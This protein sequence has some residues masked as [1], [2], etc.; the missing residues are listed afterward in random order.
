[1][2]AAARRFGLSLDQSPQVLSHFTP[3][4]GL[5][6]QRIRHFY[7]VM[8]AQALP[9]SPFLKTSA[10]LKILAQIPVRHA[11]LVASAFTRTQEHR[12]TVNFLHFVTALTLYSSTHWFYKVKCTPYTVIFAVFDFDESGSITI[13]EMT[14]MGSAVF[15]AACVMT[16][17]QLPRASDLN[18]TLQALFSEMQREQQISLEMYSLCSLF[19]WAMNEPSVIH[20]LGK[21]E[22]LVRIKERDELFSGLHTRK[23][24]TLASPTPSAKLTTVSK[25]SPA[26]R[27]QRE[28][29]PLSDAQLMYLR[30]LFDDLDPKSTGSVSLSLYLD[31]L[32]S[33]H[34]CENTINSHITRTDA[35]MSLSEIIT[36]LKPLRHLLREEPP[37]EDWRQPEISREK[38]AEYKRLFDLLD[39]NCNGMLSE[40]E[41]AQGLQYHSLR[42]V[43][44]MVS[45]YD[46]DKNKE[47]Q[48]YEFVKMLAPEGAHIPSR[49]LEEY[50]SVD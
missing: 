11:D 6:L 7:D 10:F 1:M 38:L 25:R 28:K 31:T 39:K 43:Q 23:K 46:F 12:D 2:G 48:F 3:L 36:S 33:R 9:A 50:K 37:R 29:K 5:K 13:D 44:E 32:I 41:L 14:I 47:L 35:P 49:L 16:G 22:P 26:I 24:A 40:D 42:D 27:N 15:C 8:F 45:R 17:V 21:N 30:L 18:A 34:F 19:T 20:L 4:L